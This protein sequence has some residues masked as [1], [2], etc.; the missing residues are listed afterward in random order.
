MEDGE[1]MSK[2][3]VKST[4]KLRPENIARVFEKN[5]VQ[6][7][8]TVATILAC[9]SVAVIAIAAL[10]LVGFFEF[11][12]DYTYFVLITGLMISLLPKLLNR[13]FQPDFMKYYMFISAAIFIGVM[14][15]NKNIGIYITYILIPLLSCLYLDF[16]FVLKIAAV[17]YVAMIVSLYINSAVR[18]EVLFQGY[19]R[20]HIF[21][22][23]AAGFTVEYAIVTAVLCCLVKRCNHLMLECINAKHELVSTEKERQIFDVL[24]INYTAAYCCDLKSDSIHPVKFQSHASSME[25]KRNLKNPHCYSQWVHDLFEQQVIKEASPDFLEVFDARKDTRSCRR[26][27]CRKNN[28]CKINSA[29]SAGAAGAYGSR[30]NSAGRKRP[31]EAAKH[32]NAE[33]SR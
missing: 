6:I 8:G 27:G 10:S 7:N 5:T 22:A 13:F 31:A 30:G 15:A 16:V 29:Y 14:G 25:E 11:G 4:E 3:T 9:C 21:M 17:S 1:K 24:C 26:D 23:Y 33:N 19:S 2:E 18:P 20:M 12:R 32:R 28:D